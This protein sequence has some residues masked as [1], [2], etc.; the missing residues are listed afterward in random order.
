MIL[1]ALFVFLLCPYILAGAALLLAR[2]GSLAAL[3]SLALPL[4]TRCL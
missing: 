4:L 3:L 1:L 2:Y